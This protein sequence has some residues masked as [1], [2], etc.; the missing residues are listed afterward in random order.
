MSSSSTAWRIT[1]KSAA[2]LRRRGIET[3]SPAR[4]GGC[5]AGGRR[6]SA[7]WKIRYFL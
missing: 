4:H 2:R 7:F 6:Y 3:R 1:S 5:Q